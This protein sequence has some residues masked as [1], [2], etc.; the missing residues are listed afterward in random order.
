MQSGKSLVTTHVLPRF[1]SALLLSFLG[2]LF[3]GMFIPETAA[4]ALGVVPL[5]ILLL[6]LIKSI[7]A[8]SKRKKGLSTY[9]LRLPMWLVYVFTLLFGISIYPL[10]DFYV[11]TMGM[12]LVVAAFGITSALFG[13]LFI[14]TYMSRKDFSFLGG[15]LF[16]TLLASI[17][18]GIANLFIG[19]DLVDLGLSFVG[20]L[21]FS[22]YMLYDISRMKQA[23]F[24]ESDVPA[25]VFDLYLN[26]INIF[27]DIL[28]VMNF[29]TSKD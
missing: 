29:F 27:L 21:V 5:M 23:D 24:S 13:G 11:D 18:L 25:A 7:S 12:A 28:R 2:T 9:G 26:F 3:G 1:F 4:L 19:S 10:I 20:I 22:G 6:L 17:L 16:F 8:G 14:Y 15:L